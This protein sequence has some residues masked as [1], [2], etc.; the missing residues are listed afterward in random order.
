[1]IGDFDCYAGSDGCIYVKCTETVAFYKTYTYS[2]GTSVIGDGSMQAQVRYFKV[3]PIKWRVVTTDYNGTGNALLVAENVLTGGIP[4][5][6]G[7]DTRTINEATV[8][9][10]N[11]KYSTIRAYLNGA[12]ESEDTQTKTYEGNGFLQKAFDLQSQTLIAV[13]NV[14]NS[15]ASTADTGG[16]RSESEYYCANTNDKIF[17]LSL[18]ESTRAGYGFGGYA[19][20]SD[21]RIRMAVDYSQANS[22]FNETSETGAMFYLRSPQ[23]HQPSCACAA[24]EGKASFSAE[25]YREDYGIVPALTIALP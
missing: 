3:E 8:Y 6:N 1:M 22:A 16:E 10:N 19:D 25:T 18:N 13:T 7:D 17:L 15:A 5:Y 9:K 11:Y 24:A 12:Y 4:Y 14:D 2:N 20:V 23:Y 21:S